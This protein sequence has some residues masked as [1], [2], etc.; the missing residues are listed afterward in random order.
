QGLSKAQAKKK[1][2]ALPDDATIVLPDGRTTT[3]RALLDAAAR[4]GKPDL[5]ASAPKTQSLA[6]AVAALRARE[7]ANASR[8]IQAVTAEM[9]KLKKAPPT[10]VPCPAPKVESVFPFSNITP[11][12]GVLVKGCGFGNA[13]GQFVL[14][15]S[16][17]GAE[18]P[19]GDLQWTPT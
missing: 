12:G 5:G 15:L 13:P 17:N 1:F 4:K 10:P 8:S 16:S 18:I 11:G 14:A 6:D 3:K 7:K 2:D 9:A 19:L